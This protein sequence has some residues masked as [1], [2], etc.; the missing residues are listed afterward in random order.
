MQMLKQK[1]ILRLGFAETKNTDHIMNSFLVSINM[2]KA[3][4]HKVEIRLYIIW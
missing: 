3:G 2:K 4:L 1:N